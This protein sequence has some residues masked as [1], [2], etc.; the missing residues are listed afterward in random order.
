MDNIPLKKLFFNVFLIK[1]CAIIVKKSAA[2]GL[3]EKKDSP[4]LKNFVLISI[5]LKNIAYNSV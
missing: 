3:T 2:K 1:N 5:Q 4:Q